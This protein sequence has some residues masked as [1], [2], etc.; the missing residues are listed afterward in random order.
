MGIQ[1]RSQIAYPPTC[2][3][4]VLTSLVLLAS[5]SESRACPL[6][7]GAEALQTFSS[8]FEKANAVVLAKFIS[9][10]PGKSED[11][12]GTATFLVKQVRKGPKNLVAG[13]RVT[14]Q[15]AVPAKAGDLYLLTGTLPEDSRT[16]DWV[17]PTRF[18]QAAFDY[19]IQAPATTSPSAHLKYLLGFLETSDSLIANDAYSEFANADWQDIVGISSSLSKQKFRGWISDPKTTQTRLGLYGLLLGLCGDDAD[20]RFLEDRILRPTREFRLGIDGQI[21]GYLLLRGERGLSV[22]DERVLKNQK[23]EFSERFAAMQAVRFMWTYGDGR[24]PAERLRQSIRIT[25]DDPAMTDLAIAD[26][27]RWKDWSIQEQLLTIY[28]QPMQT[29]SVKRAVIRFLLASLRDDESVSQAQTSSHMTRAKNILKTLR[30]QDS[31]LVSD[32]ERFFLV[33]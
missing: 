5:V 13:V 9:G 14:V 1:G 24:I 21:A 30:K 8:R 28:N 18:S 33:P 10:R 25:L 31:A 17:S 11:D 16:I 27:A 29:V 6:C 23:I 32:A 20:A 4:W 15:Q 7:G 12:T 22:I 3:V 26:L 2:S 19:V